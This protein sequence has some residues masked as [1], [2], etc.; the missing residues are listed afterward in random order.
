MRILGVG[1]VGFSSSPNL[2]TKH[3]F[4]VF[5]LPSERL[6]T[7]LQRT[8]EQIVASQCFQVAG[9]LRHVAEIAELIDAFVCSTNAVLL[10]FYT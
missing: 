2:D 5:C 10:W 9:T 1:G 7:L 4:Y 3:T 8:V 6:R